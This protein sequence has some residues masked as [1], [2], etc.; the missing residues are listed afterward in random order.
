MKYTTDVEIREDRGE[1]ILCPMEGFNN[2]LP[3]EYVMARM[4]DIALA[5]SALRSCI[6]YLETVVDVLD[7]GRLHECI[8][9]ADVAL[10]HIE[11]E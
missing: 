9:K 1:L 4:D 11:G 10:M 2:L 5:C 6:S 8:K 7:V 3:G